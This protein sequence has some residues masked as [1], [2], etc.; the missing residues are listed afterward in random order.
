LSTNATHTRPA[1][2]A[3]IVAH[4][5]ARLLPALVSALKAQTYPVDQLVGVDTASRDRS[6]AVLAELLGQDS[7][8][9]VA[10]STGFGEAV[11]AG[12]RNAAKQRPRLSDDHEW[13]WL[14]H[15][16]CEPAPD[17]LERLLREGGRDPA[18]GVVGPKVLDA[19][20]RRTLREVGIAIDRAG[21]RVTGIDP[22]EI[23]QGQ[24]DHERDVL[25]VGSAGMLVR[26]DVWDRLGGFDQHLKL[27]R[28]DLDFCWRVQGLGM[29]VHVATDA[30]LYHHEL[31]GRRRRD[32][33]DGSV[34]VADRRG[35]LYVLAANLPLLAMLRVVGGA[36][37]GSLGR[38][39]YYVVTKQSDQAAAYGFSVASL[40]GHPIRLFKARRRR[41]AGIR[42]AYY[43]ARISIP[44]AHTLTKLAERLSGLVG[45]GP[46]QATGGRHQASETTDQDLLDA[47]FVDQPSA[48]RQ[49]I[50]H[51][52]VQ[53]FAVL[54][55]VTLVATRRLLSLSPLG[56]GALVPA[57]GG[58]G[59]LWQ[60]YLAGFH[61]VGIGSSASTPPYLAVV[62]ALATIFGGDARI[63]VDVLLLGSV[64]LA[65]L[66]AYVASRWVARTVPARLLLAA[67]YALAPVATGAV[68]AGRLGTAVAFVLIPAIAVSAG[69]ILTA[70]PR[71]ARRAAWA[72]GLLVAIAT[73]FAPITWVFAVAFAV[74]ALA[75]RRYF[76]AVTPVNAAV[77]AVAPFFVL[78]P[79]SLSLLTSPGSFLTEAGVTT[80]ALTTHGLAATSLLALSPGGPG[81]PPVWV[82][83]GFAL[84]L[85]AL[86]L[87]TRAFPGRGLPLVIGGWTAA[88]G[89]L[90]AAV[91]L[92][93]VTVT[94]SDGGAPGAGWPGVALALAALGLLVAAAPAADWLTMIVS[95]ARD[96]LAGR[97]RPAYRAGQKFAAV[98]ALVLAATAPLAVAG[99]W[100]K[101]GVQGP[102]SVVSAPLLPSFVS[103]DSTSVSGGQY[104]TLVLRAD[105]SGLDYQVMRQSDPSLGQPELST[106]T[107]TAT[108][109]SREV[110]ALGAPDSAD[111][112]DPGML[113]GS[114]GIKW[115][116]LPAPVD[117]TLAARLDAAAGLE[118]Q[119]SGPAFDLWQVTGP[120]GRIRAV[121]PSGAVTVLSSG[122]VNMN[123]VTAPATGGTLVMAEPYGGWTAKLNGQ[124]LQ[125]LATPVDGWAQ[126]FILPAGG[127]KLSITRDSLLRPAALI[128]ELLATLAALVLALPGKRTQAEDSD[129]LA[130]FEASLEETDFLREPESR[131][132]EMVS[133]VPASTLGSTEET[134][135]THAAGG[136]RPASAGPGRSGRGRRSRRGTAAD[137]L[138]ADLAPAVAGEESGVFSSAMPSGRDT[139]LQ[140]AG[141]L[142]S[143]GTAPWDVAGDWSSRTGTHPQREQAPQPPS[144]AA[145]PW[146]DST[147]R[148]GTGDMTDED[149]LA[150]LL[151]DGSVVPTRGAG[152]SPAPESPPLGTPSPRD[153]PWPEG[154]R[155]DT[156]RPDPQQASDDWAFDA[157]PAEP[158]AP[159][160][161][162]R[163]S[164][165]PWETDPGR[166][167]GAP[168]DRPVP[169]APPRESRAPWETD[170]GRASG[171]PAERPASAAPARET[172]QPWETDPGRG[173]G[174]SDLGPVP[175][176]P[177]SREPGR[178]PWE[179][180]P[181]RPV[182][183]ADAPS[184]ARRDA[185][186]QQ[187]A[188]AA[189][190]WGTEADSAWSADLPPAVQGSGTGPRPTFSGTGPRPGFPGTG[191]RPTFPGTGPQPAD[192]G[193]GSQPRFTPIPHATFTPTGPQPVSRPTES[194][195]TFSPSG[196]H[197]TFSPSGANPMF[198][199]S[200]EYPVPPKP[201][202][203]QKS[204][205]Y[206]VSSSG[207]YPVSS[208]GA[209]PAQPS[210]SPPEQRAPWETPEPEQHAPWEAAPAPEP[211]AEQEDDDQQG[212]AG[213][214][215][216]RKP[217]RRKR[218]KDGEA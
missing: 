47:Q 103:A 186:P 177:V 132:A 95:N 102:V 53:L 156:H 154:L 77:V 194:Q 196:A 15:D 43:S 73:A 30:V 115:V 68:A 190:A 180:G 150:D 49:F 213:R 141:K 130:S 142:A 41:S 101:D 70:A 135:D 171:A 208:S 83:A 65:G 36:I 1:V 173:S 119:N 158:S 126:G 175:A 187:P 193:T 92:S 38:A 60:E 28:D 58:A 57:W 211:A 210:V 215:S 182:T 138:A 157:A 134:A 147:P 6:G 120:V 27:F 46:P 121:A 128:I 85:A 2:T 48:L 61:A 45:N 201:E 7:A 129:S 199:P 35:A 98:T 39:A 148:T 109:L 185:Q 152:N 159:S 113:L 44:P 34:R 191:P 87:P 206:P 88:L 62:A 166:A 104:R 79:W 203:A 25:A 209:Y 33:Q 124:A 55:I 123:N 117:A 9:G 84:A 163:E 89:G 161:P 13:I 26:R 189:S 51:P 181:Q 16:D 82:T 168:A 54:L 214:H 18:V 90:L 127:G 12:L 19:Q 136:G 195:P 69:R 20:D 93:R 99:Y 137:D 160:A 174:E 66:T 116:M 145:E 106:S 149:W 97:R 40:L 71:Q 118:V 96:D 144:W 143:A 32:A 24:H 188:P 52:S 176:A 86:V 179:S 74:V 8:I 200:G 56:G 105:G 131:V 167:S 75:I 50:T 76:R 153:F 216:H 162:P 67:S 165:A 202:S 217:G 22:G 107:A 80:A 94:P 184:A 42:E 11:A 170:P 72:T 114:F 81:L 64:P 29:R 155:P 218:G 17:A 14:L 198:T 151:S 125:P 204:G 23:D 59:A 37:L 197:P 110:A 139:D 205:E 108:A 133:S 63:A 183:S 3:I 178:A 146:D 140:D 100:I 192:S 21:R 4:D 111:A 91:L 10:R 78:F 207:A 122:A 31:A 169:P 5:G 112:G 164:R 212:K 172:R